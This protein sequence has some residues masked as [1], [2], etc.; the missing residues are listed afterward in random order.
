MGAKIFTC[1]IR[2]LFSWYPMK[3]SNI[4][5][6]VLIGLGLL[7]IIISALSPGLVGVSPVENFAATRI[8]RCMGGM[9][10]VQG[11][12]G[13]VRCCDTADCRNTTRSCVLT[14]TG[15]NCDAY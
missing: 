11:E 12:N 8:P 3:I 13:G 9:I 10:E 14:G 5:I 15:A 6:Y 4:T 2:D 1:E 7:M